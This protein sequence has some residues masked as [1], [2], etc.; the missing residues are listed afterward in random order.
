MDQYIVEPFYK[1]PN[2]LLTMSQAARVLGNKDYRLAEKFI[3]QGL[4]NTYSIPGKKR[5][6]LKYHEVMSLA[7][8]ERQY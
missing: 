2:Y 3:G 1:Q 7:Q 6:L 8:K 4:L 5:I